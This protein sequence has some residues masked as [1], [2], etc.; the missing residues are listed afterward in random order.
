MIVALLIQHATLMLR[1]MLS[2]VACLAVPYYSTIPHNGTIF[3][4]KNVLNIKCVLIFYNIGLKC[5]SFQEE[6]SEKLSQIYIGLHVKCRYSCQ[7]LIKFNF[8]SDFQK[9]FKFL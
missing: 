2:S 3:G 6:F 4:E 8:L 9:I 5:F 7:I 1:V